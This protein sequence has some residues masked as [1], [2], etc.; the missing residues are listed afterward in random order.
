LR[1]IEGAVTLRWLVGAAVLLGCNHDLEDAPC[2]CI[3]G[4]ACCAARNVCVPEAQALANDCGLGWGL[5][6]AFPAQAVFTRSTVAS[7]VDADGSVVNAGLNQ[8]RFDYDTDG[9]PAGLLLEDQATNLF[10][11]SEDLAN[12][13]WH[14]RT[15]TPQ[16]EPCSDPAPDGTMTATHIYNVVDNYIVIEQLIDNMGPMADRTFSLSFWI[17]GTVASS[18]DVILH[19]SDIASNWPDNDIR[20][21]SIDGTY[22][23]W[24]RFALAG[25]IGSTAGSTTLIAGIRC[26]VS[27]PCDFAGTDMCIW[28]AQVEES[29]GATSYIRTDGAAVTRAADHFSLAPEAIW[30]QRYGTLLAVGSLIAIPPDGAPAP[31]VSLQD[32]SSGAWSLVA[33]GASGG[34]IAATHIAAEPGAVWEISETSPTFVLGVPRALAA[35]YVLDGDATLAVDGVLAASGAVATPPS[36]VRTMELGGDGFFGHLREVRY[37]PVPVNLPSLQ[38]LAQVR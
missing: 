7:Y 32:D 35:T 27:S 21:S 16:I 1:A 25:T 34:A 17:K 26:S 14:S 28:G 29:P 3:E 4:Y 6:E 5:G 23:S 31:F 24:R 38:R 9:A 15:V 18:V 10:L 8:P 30:R 13:V 19:M 11:H 2:P 20:G 36:H 22:P 37:W 12:G 33:D